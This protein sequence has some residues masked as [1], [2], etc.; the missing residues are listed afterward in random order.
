MKNYVFLNRHVVGT[1]HVIRI[2]KYFNE[3]KKDTFEKNVQMRVL[4]NAENVSLWITN[5][6]F[7]RMC[8]APL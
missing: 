1:V 6:L 5:V 2:I 3:Y 4:Q 7:Q 8:T